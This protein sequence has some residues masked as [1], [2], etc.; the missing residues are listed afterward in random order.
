MTQKTPHITPEKK[1]TRESFEQL[2]VSYPIVGAV[3]LENLPAKQLQTMR[4]K[5]RGTCEIRMTKRRVM[6]KAIEAVKDRKPGIEALEPHMQGM[7]ALLFTKQN[8]FTLFKT[9]KKNQSK[10]AAKPGQKA[11][12]DIVVPAGP[13]NFAPGPVIGEL[14]SVGVKTGIEGGKVAIKADSVVAKEGAVISPKLA[15]LLQRLGIEPMRVGL[16]LTAVYEDGMIIGRSVLDVDEEQYIGMLRT[17][18]AEAIAL[19]MES[20]FLTKETTD[21]MLQKASREGAA[22]AVATSQ[23]PESG[24]KLSEAELAVYTMMTQGPA[25]VSASSTAPA[26]AQDK[27]EEKK[28]PE[29]ESMAEGLGSLFG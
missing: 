4:E 16:D 2:L 20:G 27:K 22:L 10:A 24:L 21:L 3:N 15:G 5:L 23:T 6:K 13:T 25:E 18:V 11:P 8:P 17:G 9:L 26:E 14:G 29:P 7:T 1:R 12:F 28:E 19:S